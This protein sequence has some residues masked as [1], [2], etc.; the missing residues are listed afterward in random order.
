MEMRVIPSLLAELADDIIARLDVGSGPALIR[1]YPAPMPAGPAT[2]ITTQALL[3]TLTCS[4]PCATRVAGVITFAAVTQDDA[5]D[6]DGTA[7]WARLVD[8]SGSAVID[9]DVT[10]AVDPDTG[11]PGTGAILLNDTDIVAGG[12]I[13]MNSLILTIG[14]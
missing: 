14:G 12:P 10:R 11:L 9:L 1:F 4:D 5:A 7:A 13:S 2:A 8:S 6:A 3:G